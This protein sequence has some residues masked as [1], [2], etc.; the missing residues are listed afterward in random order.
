MVGQGLRQRISVLLLITSVVGLC[1]SGIVLLMLVHQSTSLDEPTVGAARLYGGDVDSS[2]PQPSTRIA[3]LSASTPDR[4][5]LYQPATNSKTCYALRHNYHFVL[6]TNAPNEGSINAWWRKVEVLQ[7]YLPYY[8]W[9][10]GL[11]SYH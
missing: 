2:P 7:K 4:V 9:Y 11:L 6:D 1:I 10:D 3:V 5:Q 8:D